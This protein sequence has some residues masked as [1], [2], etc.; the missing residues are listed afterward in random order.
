MCIYIVFFLVQEINYFQTFL[1]ENGIESI[2]GA[3]PLVQQQP[4]MQ[5]I[6]SEMIL[7]GVAAVIACVVLPIR[8]IVSVWRQWN[9]YPD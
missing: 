1:D 9:G 8:L 3:L 2:V 5:F 7:F 6:R 4:M